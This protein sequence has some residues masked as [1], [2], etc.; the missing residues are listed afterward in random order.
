MTQMRVNGMHRQPKIVEDIHVQESF[1]HYLQWWKILE[2]SWGSPI[3]VGDG[4]EDVKQF[5]DVKRFAD[6]DDE[7]GMGMRVRNGNRIGRYDPDILHP[8]ATHTYIAFIEKKLK[9]GW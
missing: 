3:P 8:V 5:E 9:Y 6:G 2:F 4:D 1:D 7:G